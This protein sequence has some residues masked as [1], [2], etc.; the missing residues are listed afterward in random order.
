MFVG[1]LL[2][3]RHPLARFSPNNL[4]YVQHSLRRS[5]VEAL[6]DLPVAEGVLSLR[7]DVREDKA[8]FHIATDLPGVNEADVMITFDEGVLTIAGEKKLARDHKEDSWHMSE[9]SHGK[10]ER[11]LSIAAAIEADKI[12]A[13]FD[14]G[15]LMITLP[16]KPVVE[17]TVKKINITSGS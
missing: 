9:R 14:K 1:S 17:K 8:A 3:T 15:V 10:F 16:K 2:T 5:L 4:A 12:V 6:N 11:Q 7:L 13:H